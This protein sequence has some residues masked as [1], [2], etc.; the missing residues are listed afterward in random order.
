MH[1]ELFNEGVLEFFPLC[2]CNEQQNETTV[3]SMICTAQKGHVTLFKDNLLSQFYFPGLFSL[4][5][6]HT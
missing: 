1:A 2:N 6:I 4:L 5:H 3:L